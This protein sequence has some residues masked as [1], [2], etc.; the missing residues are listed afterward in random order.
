[1]QSQDSFEWLIHYLVEEHPLTVLPFLINK[2]STFKPGWAVAGSAFAFLSEA[3][4]FRG[5][6]PNFMTVWYI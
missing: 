3:E 1:M 2:G 6:R 4:E 5:L